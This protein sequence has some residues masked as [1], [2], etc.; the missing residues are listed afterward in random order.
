MKVSP[1]QKSWRPVPPVVIELDPEEAAIL[2]LVLNGNSTDS[3]QK[4][5]R[6]GCAQP[7][8]LVLL[9]RLSWTPSVDA[10]TSF[11]GKLFQELQAALQ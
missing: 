3:D 6:T 9:D 5:Y 4:A 10:A 1:V 8:A 7:D 2:V 11:M